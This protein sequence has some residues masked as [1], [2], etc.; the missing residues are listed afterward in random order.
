MHVQGFAEVL[1]RHV[2]EGADLHHAGVVD[3]HVDAAAFGHDQVDDAVNL[4]GVPD[5]AC[6]DQNIA[7]EAD[8][9]PAGALE[10]SLIA[11]KKGQAGAFPGKEAGHLQSQSPGAAGDDHRCSP[12]AHPAA[13]P[14]DPGEQERASGQ[15]QQAWH[16]V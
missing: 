15:G 7:A 6:M 2:L 9:L 16:N 8:Q 4:V 14:D 13:L 12:K 5:V 3:Q 10:F 1:S 11:G